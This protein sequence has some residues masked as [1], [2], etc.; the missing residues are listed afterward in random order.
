MA[1]ELAQDPAG[2]VLEAVKGE[3]PGREQLL[4]LNHYD[5][6][7]G[8]STV[9][10]TH[11]STSSGVGGGLTALVVHSSTTGEIDSNGGNKVVLMAVAVPPGFSVTGVRLGYELTSQESHVSQIRLA[12]VQDPPKVASVILDDSTDH[13]DM[14]PIYV[15]SAPTSIDPAVGPLLLSLRVKFKSTSDR[16]AIRGLALRLAPKK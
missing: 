10:V 8:D 2:F 12:Q 14:G 16:I 1:G 15:D 9:T 3:R 11:E 5:L 6:L 13:T 7:P 4:W